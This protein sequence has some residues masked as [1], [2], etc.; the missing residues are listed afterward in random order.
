MA[1]RSDQET[2]G[3]LAEAIVA[4]LIGTAVAGLVVL[5]GYAVAQSLAGTSGP[6][7]AAFGALAVNT[8][9]QT[10]ADRM[11]LAVLTHFAVGLVLAVVYAAVAEPRLVGPGWWR[12]MLFSLVPWLLSVAVILPVLGG[13]FLGL[14]LGAAILPAFG[15]LIAHLAYGGSLGWSYERARIDLRNEDE[16]SVLANLGAERGIAV[17]AVA[18]AVIGV[19]VAA[20]I[21]PSWLGMGAPSAWTAMLGAIGGAVGGGFLG[22]FLGLDRPA[23]YHR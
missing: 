12:G 20:V 10:V 22:S 1:V 2:S 13:G 7:G 5:V 15:N 17:G 21:A 14:G 11:A 8:A 18:G 6:L 3:W 19:L 23:Q 16:A 4:G 9:T